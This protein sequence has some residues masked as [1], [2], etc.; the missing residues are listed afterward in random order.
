MLG[1]MWG[2]KM[3]F[4]NC[5][6]ETFCTEAENK[7]IILFGAG[8]ALHG[9][10]A[11][12][13]VDTGLV[14]NLTYI[15]DNG[16]IGTYEIFGNY[17]VPVLSPEALY[18]EQGAIVVIASLN[19]MSAMYE[20]LCNMKL[21]DEIYVYSMHFIMVVSCG[22]KDPILH[23]Q[24]CDNSRPEIIDRTIHTFWFSGEP[25]PDVYKRC[26]ESWH[27]YCPDYI[28]KVWNMESYDCTKNLFMRQA[29]KKKAWAF[30]SDYARVDVLYHYGGIYMD[31]DVEVIH[32]MDVLL[33]NE[34]FFSFD[35]YNCVGL[36]VFGT[37]KENIL[38]KKIKDLYDMSEF[39]STQ[40]AVVAQPRF[41]RNVVRE[42]GVRLDGSMQCIDGM[43]FAPRSYFNPQDGVIFDLATMDQDTYTIHRSN[44]A[45]MDY[46]E[47]E[48]ERA[49][50]K[51][52][53][54]LVTHL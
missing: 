44:T 30:V 28:I 4:V 11:K 49:E 13:F 18:R 8:Q 47:K 45:W 46:G 40:M 6:L 53:W 15:I 38:L 9:W 33:G 41:I 23:K 1:Y 7:R 5:N 36:E 26:M 22:G 27:R 17:S 25:I 29:L 35:M 20:Q 16:K 3:K 48:K 10:I 37:K 12:I 21:S 43:I 32:N 51:E 54:K 19:A 50:A 31:M 52:L 14:N 24:L 39:D 42:F 2:E 34:G